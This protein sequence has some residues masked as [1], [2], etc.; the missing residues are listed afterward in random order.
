MYEREAKWI[1][2]LLRTPKAEALEWLGAHTPDS[3]RVLGERERAPAVALVRRFYDDGAVKV[4][5]IDIKDWERGQSSNDLIVELPADP[6]LRERLFK[7]QAELV[8]ARG[9]EGDADEGQQ[10]LLVGVK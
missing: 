10:F 4:F 5:A 2:K 8:R 3:M 9:F 1:N 6:R 7:L